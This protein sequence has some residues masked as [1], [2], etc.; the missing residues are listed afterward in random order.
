[1]GIESAGHSTRRCVAAAIRLA[2]HALRDSLS[3][4]AAVKVGV[5]LR[6]P[7]R[8]LY[9]ESWPT[10]ISAQLET[11]RD[12]VQRIG[13]PDDPDGPGEFLARVALLR[14]CRATPSP[15]RVEIGKLLPAHL[16]AFWPATHHSR[17]RRRRVPSTA[18]THLRLVAESRRA[19]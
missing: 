2:L 15:A 10:S 4:E 16:R 3:Y 11:R 5:R 18:G 13:G 19:S 12:F 17:R 6:P 1:M 9:Y 8:Q 7:Y 14:V